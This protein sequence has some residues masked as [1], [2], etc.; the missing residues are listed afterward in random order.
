MNKL[1]YLLP[2]IVAGI[3]EPIQYKDCPNGNYYH[4]S[5]VELSPCQT[6]PCTFKHGDTVTVKISFDAADDTAA[7][8][9]KVFGIVEGI[10]VPF[11]LP[12]PD[13]CKDSGITCPLVKGQSY[14]YTSSF[15]VLD[16]YPKIDLVVMWQL[17]SANDGN[18][19]CFTFPMSIAD[20]ASVVG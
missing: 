6:Q 19:V 20:G 8:Q 2:F 18:Q 5:A 10:P 1:L 14:V 13:G 4:A 11:P 17:N 9:S 15:K 7:L 12:N 3:A 16:T